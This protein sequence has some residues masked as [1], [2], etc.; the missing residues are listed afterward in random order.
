[1]WKPDTLSSPT[2]PSDDLTM[3]ATAWHAITVNREARTQI[4]PA[5]DHMAASPT[6]S[7]RTPRNIAE[8]GM[9]S[10]RIGGATVLS[11]HVLPGLALAHDVDSLCG[12]RHGD[13]GTATAAA[14]GTFETE[15]CLREWSFAASQFGEQRH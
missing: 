5:R 12:D 13:G 10:V 14:A 7:Y 4:K 1:M 3:L 15:L 9:T 8:S 6:R 11:A 2:G